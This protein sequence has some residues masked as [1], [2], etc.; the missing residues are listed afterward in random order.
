MNFEISELFP[1]VP[2][3]FVLGMASLILIVDVFLSDRQRGITGLLAFGTVAGA[4][5]LSLSL[6]GDAPQVVFSGAFVLDTLAS[7]LKLAVYVAVGVVFLYVPGYLRARDMLR[8]GEFY[9]LALF[10]MLGMMVLISAHSLLT[11]YLGLELMSLSLYAMVAMQRDSVVASEAAMKYFVLGA[12]ASAMLLYGMSMLYGVTGT[13]DLAEI[14]HVLT[15]GQ[16]SRV[17]LSFALVFV[18]IGV[19]FK[20]G[21][22][23]FHMWVPDVYHG[24]PTAVTLFVSTAPKLAAFAMMMRLLVDGLGAIQSDWQGILIILTLLSVAIGNVVAIAQ[25][26][27]KRMLAYSAISHVGFILI[28]VLSGTDEGYAAALFYAISY[29]VMGLASF[30][31]VLLMSRAGFEADN[32]DD[33]RGLSDRSPWFA[34]LM[35]LVMFSMAGVPPLVG[36]WAKLFVIQAA[37][38]VDLVWLAIAAVVFSVIGA[39]FYLRLIKIMYFDKP[40]DTRPLEAGFEVRWALSANGLALL[41]LGILPGPL[42]AACAL[43]VTG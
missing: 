23:P 33:Y 30:G 27:I 26:N 6:Y 1:A 5:L 4:F 17:V 41:G 18:I 15:G 40:V 22:V 8:G 31:T 20:L 19:A 34:F 37:V 3:L 35:L 9:V 25:T 2:E 14:N 29:V 21:A 13:L 12:M 43:A 24:A 39:F 11:V 42:L 10:S 7:L 32:L 38:R 36:F 28:G 16:V